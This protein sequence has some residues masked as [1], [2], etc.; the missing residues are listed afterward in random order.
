M[1]RAT[2]R[3]VGASMPRSFTVFFQ[4]SAG[5]FTV[6]NSGSAASPP[7]ALYSMESTFSP[8]TS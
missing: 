8:V 6:S 4:R 2:G 7:P 5:S 1:S 3:T